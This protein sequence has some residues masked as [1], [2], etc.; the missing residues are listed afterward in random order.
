M[1]I[2]L[3]G[4]TFVIP[5][6]PISAFIFYIFIVILWRSGVIP[7]PTEVFGWLEGLF[8]VF[9]LKILFLAAFLEGLVFVGLYF[10]GSTIILLSVVL[11]DG[12]PLTLVSVSLV[13]TF[14]LMITSGI[15]YLFGRVLTSSRS[16]SPDPDKPRINRGLLL[17]ALHPDALAF[18][19]FHAGSERRQPKEL[20]SVPF[21]VFP[22]GLILAGIFYFLKTPLRSAVETPNVVFGVLIVWFVI[23]FYLANRSKHIPKPV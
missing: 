5:K 14:A 6:L 21:I 20:L 9:G 18:Y 13:V 7:S 4:K 2:T 11:S 8:S 19:F 16:S 22:Y 23:A 15:N 1:N 10:P 12:K 17:S 3:R